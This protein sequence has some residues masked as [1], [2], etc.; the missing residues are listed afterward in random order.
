MGGCGTRARLPA[1]PAEKGRMRHQKKR[2]G[3]VKRQT[4]KGNKHGKRGK[5]CRGEFANG[6]RGRRGQSKG[7]KENRDKR[8]KHTHIPSRAVAAKQERQESSVAFLW[9]KQMTRGNGQG[10]QSKV[11]KRKEEQ[12][13]HRQRELL[14]TGKGPG[15]P[16][17]QRTARRPWRAGARWNAPTGG[18][19]QRGSRLW[20]QMTVERN[21]E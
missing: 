4:R 16:M 13:K 21:T 2:S 6:N 1:G 11:R 20:R 5:Q 17:L 3:I 10:M 19:V 8:H 18:I 14:C 12:G 7:T 9:Q 15:R